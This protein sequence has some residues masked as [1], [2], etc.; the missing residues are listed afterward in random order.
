LYAKHYTANERTDLGA[1][2]PLQSLHEIYMLRAQLDDIITLLKSCQDE[3]R[4]VKLYNSLFTGTQRLLS[5]M[6]THTVLVGDGDEM[7]TD[8]WKGLAM[9]Q[10][11][12]GLKVTK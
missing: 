3:D 9:F 7:L 8:F 11:E 10:K 6:R 1:M 12:V 4:K 2:P 5:A